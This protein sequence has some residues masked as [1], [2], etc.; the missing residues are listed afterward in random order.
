MS[1]MSG[2]LDGL[3][4]D[5]DEDFKETVGRGHE[6]DGVARGAGGPAVRQEG[7]SHGRGRGGGVGRGGDLAGGVIEGFSQVAGPAR[8]RGGGQPGRGG[9][10]VCGQVR[11]AQG[12]LGDQRASPTSRDLSGTGWNCLNISGR[13]IKSWLPTNK[14]FHLS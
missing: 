2:Y 4:F 8:G 7:I 3:N 11:G 1:G 12:D 6:K 9:I 10:G 13:N 5:S 14:K